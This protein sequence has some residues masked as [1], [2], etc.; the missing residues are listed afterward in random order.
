MPKNLALLIDADNAQPDSNLLAQIIKQVSQHGTLTIRRAYG[1]WMQPNPKWGAI[2]V[3]HSIEPV[4]QLRYVNGK[5]A[6]D[7]ALII[8]AMDI[9]HAGNVQGF[10]I[11]SSDSDYTPL[12]TRI[13]RDGLF[14]MG[15]GRKNT[16]SAFVKACS[17]FVYVE[18]LMKAKKPAQP[19]K[20]AQKKPAQPKQNGTSNSIK[21]KKKLVKL[22]RQAVEKSTKDD[23][24][25]HLGTLGSTL[26]D[27]DSKFKPSVYGHSTLSKLVKAIPDQVEVKGP[28]GRTYI[29][30]KNN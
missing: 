24:W 9:L 14:V 15:I 10:C 2:M 18:S 27:L 8:G 20:P 13:R 11:V 19:K 22:L 23:G 28:V 12:C 1:N 16:P 30:M 3:E 4:T 25:V 26:H 17:T 6:T 7:I 29:R 21:D 5:N